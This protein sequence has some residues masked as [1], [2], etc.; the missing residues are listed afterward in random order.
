VARRAVLRRLLIVAVAALAVAGCGGDA[1]LSHEAYQRV[2]TREVAQ[3]GARIVA[4]GNDAKTATAVQRAVDASADRLAKL[5]P[6]SDAAG[7]NDSLVRALRAYA[8]DLGDFALDAKSLP[9]SELR[10][11]QSRLARSPAVI[12]I[13]RAEADLRRAGYSLTP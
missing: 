1:R 9:T 8:L 2:L 6:P 3:L 4:A 13:Q 5:R 10:E 12:D 7:A 11:S